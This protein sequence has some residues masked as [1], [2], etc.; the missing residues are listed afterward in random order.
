[1]R[2]SVVVPVHD[3][4][5]YLGECLDSILGQSFSDIEVIAVDDASSDGSAEILDEYA[6]ADARLAVVHLSENVGLGTARNTGLDLASADYVLFVDSDDSL[7]DGALAA[8]AD[9]IA[10]TDDPDLVVFDFV[11]TYPTGERTPDSLSAQ[12]LASDPDPFRAESRPR[13]LDLFPVAWNKAYRRDFLEAGGFRF[14]TGSYEDLPWTYPILITAQ[15][16]VTL[17]RVCYLYRQRPG[18]ILRS[19]DRRHLDFFTQF[20]MVFDFLDAHPELDAWRAPLYDRLTRHAPWIMEI[21]DRV[22]PEIRRD[23]FAAASASFR[24]HRPHGFVAPSRSAGVKI[25]L[26]ERG[27]Y[28]AFRA[29]QLVN[30]TKRRAGVLRRR[31]VPAAAADDAGWRTPEQYHD[32]PTAALAL[33]RADGSTDAQHAAL[34]AVLP[35]LEL[36]G[37]FGSAVGGLPDEVTAPFHQG[38]SDILDRVDADVIRA[39][40]GVS[41]QLRQALLVG[42]KGE[43]APPP[44]RSVDRLRAAARIR[45]YVGGRTPDEQVMLDGTHVQPVHAKLRAISYLG[46]VLLHERITWLPA[47]AELTVDGRR[48]E[49][50]APAAANSLRARAQRVRTLLNP[51]L[52]RR[53]LDDLSIRVVARRPDARARYTNAWLLIDRDSEAQDNAEHLYRHLKQYRPD[54][55]AWFVL[56]RDSADWRRL[57][58]AGSRLLEFGSREHYVALLHCVHLVSSQVDTYVNQPFWQH[59]LGTPKWRFTFL[60]H[61]VT[62]D[63]LSRWINDKPI[64]LVLTA[65]PDEHRGFVADGTPYVLTSLDVALTGFPRHDRLLELGRAVDRPRLALVMPTWR[66]DLLGRK[67]RGNERTLRPDFWTSD[68]ARAWRAVL[69]SERL[70]AICADAG[71]TLTFVPHPNLQDYL[72]TSPL[73]PDIAVARFR[74]VDVQRLLAEAAVVVTDYSSLAFEAAYLERPVVYYH[75]DPESFFAGSH[76]Y[77]KGFWSYEEQGFGP[78]TATAEATLDALAKIAHG[79]S[80][81]VYAERART[82]FPFRDGECCARAVEAIARLRR[83]C[84]ADDLVRPAVSPARKSQ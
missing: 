5:P 56:R 80:D 82:T 37:R 14:P 19:A 13:Y 61:G 42:L 36:D 72:D 41:E 33:L 24:R 30:L 12:L 75:F 66:Q 60:Q 11:R 3:M 35:Y 52:L 69:E 59:L 46:K 21:R 49:T 55:N 26:I 64:D 1:V 28:R 7:A 16:I 47:A 34:D 17:D 39:H 15:R 78:V 84:S 50:W 2:F 57:Q 8:I 44:R 38:L 40:P 51:R 4:R 31:P 76:V 25:R 45:Y 54:I 58:E 32:V 68:F 27:D 62:K 23:F 48:A 63:D 43:P 77:R 65:T 53:I 9:R 73:P 67:G 10:E 81:P 18:S 6:A 70:R 83:P 29:A 22:S 71:W 79:T 20:G 74:D